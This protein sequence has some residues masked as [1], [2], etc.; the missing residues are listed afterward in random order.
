MRSMKFPKRVQEAERIGED[1]W[2]LLNFTQLPHDASDQE[3]I[4]ALKR[5]RLWQLRKCDETISKIDALI[6]DI[7]AS[8]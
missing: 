6:S 7:Q 2:E 1:S 4:K 5:D 8:L 3:Q